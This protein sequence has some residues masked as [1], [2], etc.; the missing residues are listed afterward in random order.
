MSFK[1]YFWEWPGIMLLR[2]FSRNLRE[3]SPEQ[4]YNGAECFVALPIILIAMASLYLRG[5]FP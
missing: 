3:D 4:L 1:I 5:A 2:E